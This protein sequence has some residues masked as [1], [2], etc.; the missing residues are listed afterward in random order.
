MQKIVSILITLS[1]CLVSQGNIFASEHLQ[2]RNIPTTPQLESFL[3]QIEY[4]L[5]PR[6]IQEVSKIK[7]GKVNISF[8]EI[9]NQGE[10][11]IPPKCSEVVD[12]ISMSRFVKNKLAS[13]KLSIRDAK[14]IRYNNQIQ[15]YVTLRNDIVLHSGFLNII[16]NT[17]ENSVE[18]SCEHKNLYRLAIANVI[19]GLATIYDSPKGLSLQDQ[20]DPRKLST[21]TP[22]RVSGALRYAYL[23]N[24]SVRGMNNDGFWPRALNPF[25][26]AG[27]FADHFA[28]NLE[29]FLL[30]PEYACRKPL[31]QEFFSMLFKQDNQPFDLYQTSRECIVNTKLLI[32]HRIRTASV[33]ENGLYREKIS[34]TRSQYDLDPN[35]IY[36]IYYFLAGAGAGAGSFGHSMYRIASCKEGQPLTEKCLIQTRDLIVNP[37]ANPLEMRLDNM[38]GIFGGYPSMFLVTPMDE[39]WNEYGTGELRNLYNIP[40]I[41]EKTVDGEGNPINVMPKDQ[42]KR[43]IYATL[44]QYWNY[45]G[46][47]K[48]VSNNCSDETMRLYQMSSENEKV[49]RLNI[50]KPFDVSDKLGKLGLADIAQLNTQEKNQSIISK[51]FSMISKKDV[52]WTDFEKACE[53]YKKQNQTLISRKCYVYGAVRDLALLGGASPNQVDSLKKVQKIAEKWENLTT[54]DIKVSKQTMTQRSCSEQIHQTEQELVLKN[55]FEQYKRSYQDLINRAKTDAEKDQIN[56]NFYLLT[57]YIDYQRASSIGNDAVQIAY[58]V[59]YNKKKEGSDAPSVPKNLALTS[60]EIAKIKDAV[61]KYT[62]LETNMMPYQSLSV[63]P[64]YGIPLESEVVRGDDFFNLYI[65]EDTATRDVIEATKCLLGY[66]YVVYK[67]VQEFLK[68][69]AKKRAQ[70]ISATQSPKR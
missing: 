55:S 38:R 58:Q 47:Y 32:P 59:G 46:N 54:P 40:L 23:A 50:L 5:P 6:L 17:Q 16:Q 67:E 70:Y 68:E 44:D 3:N 7:H 33:D 43:F 62:D 49:L 61:E 4:V 1:T 28:Y 64:G 29:Y 42:K 19:H 34:T 31:Q 45:Y 65:Q 51:L 27:N 24:G 57:Y 52:K 18:F 60:E 39:I 15:S 26:F 9:K 12:S 48:F 53:N 20:R 14:S 37:R 63:K 41:G 21:T 56:R 66:E 30:D 11:I 13:E 69:L 8:E 35:R 22:N 2:I 10:E 25:E 36:N